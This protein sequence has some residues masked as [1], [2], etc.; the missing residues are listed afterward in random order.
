M[1]DDDDFY[2]LKTLHSSSSLKAV[3]APKKKCQRYSDRKIDSKNP[4]SIPIHLKTS[5]DNRQERRRIPKVPKIPTGKKPNAPWQNKENESKI[6]NKY[7][8]S[9]DQLKMVT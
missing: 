7:K 1:L 8:T 9:L 5:I 6:K 3:D 4:P 2:P